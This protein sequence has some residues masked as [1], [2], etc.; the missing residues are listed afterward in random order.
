M[1]VKAHEIDKAYG[2]SEKAE[3]VKK[4]ASEKVKKINEDYK[5][6][7]KANAAAT[8]VA[9][10]ATVKGGLEKLNQGWTSVSTAVTGYYNEYKAEV[11]RA[12][13][14]KHKEKAKT[15]AGGEGQ[16]PIPVEIQ[17]QEKD[18]STQSPVVAPQETPQGED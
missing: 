12:I 11:D 16:P 2:I 15:L 8:S 7:E 5:I 17:L 18:A 1:K 9:S 6:S 4:S 14:E 3:T 13:D 10:N